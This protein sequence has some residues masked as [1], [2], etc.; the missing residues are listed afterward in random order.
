MFGPRDGYEGFPSR[1]KVY[2]DD[3]MSLNTLDQKEYGS[4][5]LPVKSDSRSLRT[6][7][8]EGAKPRSGP[9]RAQDTN[10]YSGLSLPSYSN[11]SLQQAKQPIRAQL[12]S[13][14][15]SKN[16]ANFFGITPPGSPRSLS[17]QN[18]DREY[19]GMPSKVPPKDLANFY[20]V[21]PPRSRAADPITTKQGYN[22]Q[23]YYNNNSTEVPAKDLA[24]FYG[25]TPPM[26]RQVQNE[27]GYGKP[28]RVLRDEK[29]NPITHDVAGYSGG[30]G[31]ELPSKAV[32]G[33]YG[34]TPPVSRP[35][36]SNKDLANFYGVTPPATGKPGNVVGGY[37]N[38]G[39]GARDP[40]NY[41]GDVQ[42]YNQGY[43]NDYKPAGNVQVSNKDLA[44]FYGV[45]PPPTGKP[46]NAGYGYN[47]NSGS[48]VTG[49]DLANFYGVTP[50]PT[51]KPAN[52]GYN[53]M[54]SGNQLTAKDLANFYGVTPPPTGKPENAG[55][56]YNNANPTNQLTAKDLANFYGVT[57]PPTGKPTGNTYGNAGGN[58]SNKDIANFYG[59]TPPP[60]GGGYGGNSYGNDRLEPEFKYAAELAG[61]ANAPQQYVNDPYSKKGYN[62]V[63]TASRIFN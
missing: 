31:G 51:G 16:A 30:G 15:Y 63:S 52:Q 1:S 23:G 35:G 24:N 9:R 4:R 6:D 32:A 62:Q 29:R 37:E 49:K 19:Q 55:Y 3:L 59:V 53:N 18:P 36:I 58:L 22:N 60:T 14:D 50:P 10:A 45:T 33:F 38:R 48:Q 5:K 57:P 39:Q 56:G 26:S 17:N 2:L 28:P 46:G 43:V 34:A 8:I 25:V 21:T 13:E 40:P 47:Q 61:K 20:G 44:N 12:G 11:P 41:Y 7:D 54:S 27:G 42:E